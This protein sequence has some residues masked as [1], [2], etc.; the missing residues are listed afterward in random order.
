M[1]KAKRKRMEN[2]KKRVL[3]AFNNEE[4]GRNILFKC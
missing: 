3:Q 1:F 2:D 4:E